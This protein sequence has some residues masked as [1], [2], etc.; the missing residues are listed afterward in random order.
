MKR[1][2][3]DW[4]S[5]STWFVAGIFA[6]GAFWYFLGKDDY[7]ATALSA[8]GAVMFAIVSIVLQR[9]NDRSDR[10]R[11]ARERLTDLLKQSEALLVRSNEDPLPVAELNEWI[12][13]TTEDVKTFLDASYATRLNNFTGLVFYGDGSQKSKYRNALDGRMRR[14]MEFLKEMQD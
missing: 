13:R 5:T 4:L 1:P 7:V 10:F 12:D 2:V 14:L 11:I 8:V 3:P 9:I 6:T